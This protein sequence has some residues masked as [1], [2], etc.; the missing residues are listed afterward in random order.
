LRVD[1]IG[2]LK[3]FAK[4]GHESASESL[5]YYSK[6]GKDE[7]RLITGSF[8]MGVVAAIYWYIIILYLNALEFGSVEIGLIFGLGTVAGVVSLLL[9]GFLADKFGRRNLL[10]LGLAGDMIGLALFLSEKNLIVFIAASVVANF[11][12]SIIQPA[13]MTLLAGKT[14]TSK[15]KVLY[16]LQGFSNQLGLTFAAL[17]GMYLPGILPLDESTGYWYMI[18]AGA[19]FAIVPIVLVFLT[20]DAR[21]GGTEVP[22]FRGILRGFDSRIRRILIMFS[23]Q[24]ALIGLG[25]GLLV[26]WFPLIF[27]DGMGASNTQL[28]LMFALSN[29]AVAFGW[30]VVP[31]FAE[32]RGS[33]VLVTVCQL[34]SIGFMVAIPYS[35]YLA[36]AAILYMI[37]NVLMLIPIPVLNAYVINIAPENIRASFFAL[38]QVSWMV[39]FAIAESMS[40]FL[41]ADDYSK[42]GP[43][44]ACA[45]LYILATLIFYFYFRGI[46]EPS[47]L[48]TPPRQSVK[49]A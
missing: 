14:T 49:M 45:G 24:N 2:S 27:Q 34:A 21:G 38:S 15:V 23:L 31:K 20:S 43:F 16:G 30:F 32:F 9:T 39:P 11:G 7:R 42:V 3:E 26:P 13:L 4:A 10:L 40:G 29:I 22:T 37:R 6:S 33:V 12:G 5:S 1:P 41:W 8:F 48:T 17:A 46:Q 28:A 25:A 18:A 19:A 35:P 44:F 47:D 36:G